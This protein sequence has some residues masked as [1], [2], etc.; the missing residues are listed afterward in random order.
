MLALEL[1]ADEFERALHLMRQ[2]ENAL[3]GESGEITAVKQAMATLAADRTET[4]VV[5]GALDSAVAWF[6]FGNE[7][8][9]AIDAAV[10]NPTSPEDPWQYGPKVHDMGGFS[11]NSGHERAFFDVVVRDHGAEILEEGG[12][13]FIGQLNIFRG[14]GKQLPLLK[15]GIL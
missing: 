2:M 8:Y 9:V 3:D 10:I 14:A 6:S 15:P 1:R 5:T 11:P 7:T 12:D 13:L 4:P